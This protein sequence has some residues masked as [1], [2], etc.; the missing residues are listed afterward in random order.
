VQLVNWQGA[1]FGPGSE[2]L[3][4]ML[5][6]VVVTVSLAGLYRQV[7]LQ[8]NASAIEQ[9]ESYARDWNAEP[10][11]RSRL[12]VLLALREGPYS[13]DVPVEEALKEYW[14]TTDFSDLPLAAGNAIAGFWEKLGVLAREGHI[15]P[16][17]IW[18][19]DPASVIVWW[20][21]GAPLAMRSR[22]DYGSGIYENFEWLAE[23][24]AK[25]NRKAGF[26]DPGLLTKRDVD[27]Q[28]QRCRHNIREAKALRTVFL[29]APDPSVATDEVALGI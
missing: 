28:I 17:I 8:S 18:K 6:F 1:I 20:R 19:L 3:W 14:E 2:W 23:A 10:L 11:Q 22:V 16:E 7:R 13:R 9:A 4:S 21:M 26:D 5:Q 15:R 12:S 29:A 24:M 25:L 27:L